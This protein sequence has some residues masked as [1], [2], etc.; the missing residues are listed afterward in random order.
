MFLIPCGWLGEIKDGSLKCW[1]AA[2]EPGSDG[3]VGP[4]PFR[5]EEQIIAPQRTGCGVRYLWGHVVLSCDGPSAMTT[6]QAPSSCRCFGPRLG[7]HQRLTS[8][9]RLPRRLTQRC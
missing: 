2:M 1:G 3:D 6:L 4:E 8:S 9:C 5:N 7:L